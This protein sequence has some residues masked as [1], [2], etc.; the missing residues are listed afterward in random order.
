VALAPDIGP[1]YLKF[2]SRLSKRRYNLSHTTSINGTF[3]RTEFAPTGKLNHLYCGRLP[4]LA[5][6]VAT[7][8]W[9]QIAPKLSSTNQFRAGNAA[10][11]SGYTFVPIPGANDCIQT[12]LIT[13]TTATKH[14]ARLAKEFRRS[15][16]D[17]F[18]FSAPIVSIVSAAPVSERWVPDLV[19]QLAFPVCCPPC[20]ATPGRWR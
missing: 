10:S 2:G 6:L 18:V 7:S 14:S 3:T 20:A 11:S 9:S 17:C 13:L 15:R 19:G 5:P 16:P 8:A 1:M 12:D 4:A